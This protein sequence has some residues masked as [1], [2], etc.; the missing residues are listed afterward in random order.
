MKKLI[1]AFAA[2][3]TLFATFTSAQAADLPTAPPPAAP[4]YKAPPPVYNWTGFYIGGNLGTD[5][6]QGDFCDRFGN[7]IRNVSK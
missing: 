3:T 7:C 2:A 5:W 4:A 1:V 6:N